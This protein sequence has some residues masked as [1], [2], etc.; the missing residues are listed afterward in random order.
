LKSRVL[1]IVLLGSCC[2]LK[3]QDSLTNVSMVPRYAIKFSPFH[4]I[5]FYR[6]LQVAYEHRLDDQVTGQ[7]DIGWVFDDNLESRNFANKRGFKA[8]LELRYYFEQN[9]ARR[10]T[11]YASLEGYLNY[12]NFDR[13]G[14][15]EECFDISCEHTFIRNFKYKRMYRE[16]GFVYKFGKIKYY[17]YFFLDM[18][19]GIRLR[20]VRYFNED[21][22]E[23]RGGDFFQIPNENDRIRPSPNFGFR[24]GYLIK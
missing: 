19:V 1:L 20:F 18:N 14:S 23:E 2:G 9:P 8:K 12:V 22:I 13:E 11:Y 3:A 4:L 7:A 5:G 15:R 16:K 21:G 6:T 10:N 17:K 24:F